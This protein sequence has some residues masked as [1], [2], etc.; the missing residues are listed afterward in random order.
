MNEWIR[1]SK[2]KNLVDEYWEMKDGKRYDDFILKLTEIL[3]I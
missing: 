2:I 1:Y 3:Q